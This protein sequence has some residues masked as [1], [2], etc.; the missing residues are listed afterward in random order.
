MEEGIVIKSTVVFPIVVTLF[1]IGVF[2][3]LSILFVRAGMFQP[4][5]LLLNLL[6]V[7]FGT[8][9]IILTKGWQAVADSRS[10]RIERSGQLEQELIIS[11]IT[12][13]YSESVDHGIQR[14][15][16]RSKNVHHSLVIESEKGEKILLNKVQYRSAD[17]RG[18]KEFLLAKNKNIKLL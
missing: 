5:I 3:C 8:V 18:L 12:K 2:A 16:R 6:P 13:I 1:I 9:L 15:S 4:W 10:V 17:L 11:E 14:S 7:L